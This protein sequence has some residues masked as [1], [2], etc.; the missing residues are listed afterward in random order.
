MGGPRS[1]HS[2]AIA[3]LDEM[4]IECGPLT[5]AED[6]ALRRGNWA[7]GP[8]SARA[9]EHWS[10]AWNRRTH[11]EGRPVAAWTSRP[12]ISRSIEE[13]PRQVERDER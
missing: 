8:F 5:T 11:S 1:S 13:R 2:E 7:M 12:S 6:A 4:P 9:R 10:G 3:I